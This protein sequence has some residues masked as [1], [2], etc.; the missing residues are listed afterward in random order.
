MFSRSRRNL[1]CWFALSM[2]SILVVFA[3]VVYS[4]EVK[5]QLRNFDR[6]LAKKSKAMAAE[7][8]YQLHQG[9]WQVDLEDVPF[10]GSNMLPPY[11]D[12][13]YARWYNPEGKLVQFF[14]A[15]APEQLIVNPGFQTIKTSQNQ[16]LRQVTLPVIQDNLLIG[17]L[18]VASPMT[19]I[20]ENLDQTRLSLTLGVPVALGLIGLTG[21]Y[22]GGLAMKPIR[23]AYEQL[24]RFTADASHELRAPLAAVLS[25]AQVGLLSPV[26]EDGSQQLHRLENIVE[27]TK[28]MSVLISNL[29]FLARHEGSLAP[30]VLKRID[31]VSLLKPLVN[32]YNAQAVTQNLSLIAHLPEQ[33]VMLNAD[34]ELLQQAITN[35]LNNAFKY[36]QSGGTVQLQIFTQSHRVII[37]VEDNG[38]GIPAADLPHIFE[39]F[40]RV[41]AVRSRQ[42][43]GFGLGLSIAQQIVEAHKGRITAKSN[44]G[45]GS[46][47]QIELPLRSNF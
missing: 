20:R 36:T 39:R 45:R 33:P 37:Q 21:W 3:G 22:L 7:V 40:Y 10:L 24:Q 31:L 16:W 41:D 19:S 17:Y 27:I 25:N 2:G 43:G 30:K 29:L 34:P 12:I 11:N 47:F 8:Q 9:R 35:L 46:T 26:D 15:T 38:I 4:I 42:T 32:E 5:D 18:Q 13:V 44:F 23:R 1:A 14:G 6:E 28:S